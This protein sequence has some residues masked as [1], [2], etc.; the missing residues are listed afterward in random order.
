MDLSKRLAK[1]ATLVLPA[2]VLADVGCDHGYLAIYLAER[3]IC[4]RIIAM[5][6]NKGPLQKAAE[7]IVKYGYGSYIETRLSDGL[8]KLGQGEA[9]GYVCAGMGG[10]LALQIMWNDRDKIKDMKQIILQP[11]SELWLVRRTLKQW[12]FLI[13]K[14]AVE[15]EDG[16]YYF[17]MRISP[18]SDLTMD[19]APDTDSSLWPGVGENKPSQD[20]MQE[21]DLRKAAYELFAQE[22]LEERNPLLKEYILREKSRLTEVYESLVKQSDSP[23]SERR[24]MTVA[25]ELAVLEW[26]LAR[27]ER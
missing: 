6:V 16:K 19:Y 22:L 12:G 3:K 11:Q 2:D 8:D 10:P 25:K 13:E 21:E 7:N 27:Y 15:Y 23:K 26:A 20:K 9:E 17:M 1:V 5:D 4:K 24:S 14:E 18:G